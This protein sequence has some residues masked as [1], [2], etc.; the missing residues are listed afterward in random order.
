MTETVRTVADL[1]TRVAAWRREGMPV[2]LV[3]TMG[4][5]HPGHLSLVDAG[6][7]RGCRV[8]VSIFVN[9]T[10]FG[11]NEDLARYP[12]QETADVAL[13]AGRGAHLAFCPSVD[14]M[15]AQ[16]SATRVEVKGLT[17]SLCGAARPAHFSGMA[18]IVTKLLLQALPDFAMFGEKDW[19]QLQVVRRMVR[20]LDI[21]VEIVGCPTV[22]EADGLALSSRNLRLSAGDRTIAPLLNREMRRIAETVARGGNATA[23]LAEARASLA[24]AGFGR[25]DYLELRHPE[26]LEPAGMRPARVFA[27]V[28]LGDVRLIDNVPV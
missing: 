1:R 28:W 22:R 8:V 7:A 20:D 15:Y 24:T 21:P 18:T 23:A 9:P 5:L 19:Q 10:Q 16:G 14:E 4:A 26:T 2:A 27:A 17:D 25:I 12:R 13:L 3:P 11:P 6:L